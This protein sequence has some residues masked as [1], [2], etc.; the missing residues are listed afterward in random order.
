MQNAYNIDTNM[1][2]PTINNRCKKDRAKVSRHYELF[3]PDIV[4]EITTKLFYSFSW[5]RFRRICIN[6]DRFP[7]H[8]VMMD[9]KYA[10]R[11]SRSDV[12][13]RF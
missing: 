13:R 3:N 12:M 5:K 11:K 9:D 10:D 8:D 6:L 1:D 4:D 7:N 2:N